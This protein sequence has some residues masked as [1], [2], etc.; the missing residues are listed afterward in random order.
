MSPPPDLESL[1]AELSKAVAS[2]RPVGARIRFV[3]PDFGALVVDGAGNSNKVESDDGQDV[4]CTVTISAGDHLAMLRR[5]LDQ[6]RAFR[7]GRMLITGDV[8][9]AYRLRLFVEAA[10]DAEEAG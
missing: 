3:Y 5:E 8:A 7:E 10:Q 2:A 6:A 1:G 9:I 4:D